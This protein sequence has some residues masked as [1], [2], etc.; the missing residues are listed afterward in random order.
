MHS[1]TRAHK[2]NPIMNPGNLSADPKKK[3]SLNAS[4]RYLLFTIQHCCAQVWAPYTEI[5]IN[6]VCIKKI[7]SMIKIQTSWIQCHTAIVA[8]CLVPR[9]IL[10]YTAGSFTSIRHFAACILFFACSQGSL[11]DLILTWTWSWSYRFVI[12][13]ELDLMVL[14]SDLNLSWPRI[15]MIY[16]I[17]TFTCIFLY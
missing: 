12:W 16:L 2:C 11:S 8:C 10:C 15:R 4:M 13:T 17:F 6:L 3:K 5:P 9:T 14:W 1:A 7:Y